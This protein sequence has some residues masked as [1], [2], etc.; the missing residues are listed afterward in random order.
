MGDIGGCQDERRFSAWMTPLPLAVT[1]ASSPCR[2]P[3]AGSPVSCSS[4][5]CQPLKETGTYSEQGSGTW[6]GPLCFGQSPFTETSE[7]SAGPP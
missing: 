2:A 1:S 7:K 5:G 6:E 4:S 3:V